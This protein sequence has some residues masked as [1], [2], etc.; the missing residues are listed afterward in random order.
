MIVSRRH[1][2]NRITSFKKKARIICRRDNKTE[3]PVVIDFLGEERGKPRKSRKVEPQEARHREPCA[4]MHQHQ[5]EQTHY[6]PHSRCT[7][8]RRM[9]P[10]TTR[11]RGRCRWWRRTPTRRNAMG[12]KV[13]NNMRNA[14]GGNN[15]RSGMH[16]NC[17]KRTHADDFRSC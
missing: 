11:R 1:Y 6:A 5:A 8:T 10:C 4:D 2:Q 14:A 12:G 17:L 13:T 9:R 3:L 7:C 16:R 15:L